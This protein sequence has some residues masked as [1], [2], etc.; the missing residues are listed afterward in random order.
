[1][2]ITYTPIASTTLTSNQAT[3]TFSSIS[4][5][6]TDLELVVASSNATSNS[7]IFINV[8]NDY[9]SNYAFTYLNGDGGSATSGR[10]Q[11]T[12]GVIGDHSTVIST[13]IGKFMNYSNTNTF[14]TWLYRGGQ[15]GYVSSS[16][17]NLWRST[18]AINRIDISA[19][20]NRS[21]TAGS[22][23]TLYGIKAA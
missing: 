22:T 6:Y 3:I 19:T 20:S 14:K 4:S 18:A 17:V 12:L 5:A 13:N 10:Y 8:N 11:G 15:A 9:G 23:F 16:G 7:T 1:M 21:F 2:P